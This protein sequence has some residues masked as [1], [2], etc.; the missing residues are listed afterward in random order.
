M[1]KTV[2]PL[3]WPTVIFGLAAVLCLIMSVADFIKYGDFS[4]MSI[5]LNL[6][7]I[8]AFVCFLFKC[9]SQE[10]IFYDDNSFTVG[11]KNYRYEEINNV[12][13]KSE[14]II[15]SASTLRVNIFICEEKICSFTK[16]DKGGKDF[17]AELKNHGVSVTIDI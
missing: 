17:I 2:R 12:T 7:I 1:K 14:Q 8:G 5:I 11:E 4:I 16:D 6:L 3:L 10:K 13:V 9:L 15:R